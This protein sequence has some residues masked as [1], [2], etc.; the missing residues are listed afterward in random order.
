LL[1]YNNHYLLRETSNMVNK[2]ISDDLFI[3]GNPSSNKS[4][5][6]RPLDKIITL[7]G[8]VE[9]IDA[10]NGLGNNQARLLV[11]GSQVIPHVGELYTVIFNESN[12]F[13]SNEDLTYNPISQIFTV[14]SI[15][16]NY[17]QP[18]TLDPLVLW[19]NATFQDT[20]IVPDLTTGD[21]YIGNSQTSGSIFL[22]AISSTVS[23]QGK[24]IT[25]IIETNNIH[26]KTADP[27]ILWPTS[28]TQNISIGPDLTS[29][30]ISIGGSLI[31]GRINLG[32]NRG[33]LA[34]NKVVMRGDLQYPVITV[35]T[36]LTSTTTTVD[37]DHSSIFK[38][39]TEPLT[40][41]PGSTTTFTILCSDCLPTS[42]IFVSYNYTG[43]GMIIVNINPEMAQFDVIIGNAIGGSLD[44]SATLSFWVINAILP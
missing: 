26:S 20:R 1:N 14:P 12:G 5:I 24:I 7:E 27:L 4:T 28:T 42:N 40:G 23:V 22:G 35:Y 2:V 38:V 13:G 16:T 43:S 10:Y 15:A 30:N 31:T 34:S 29:G 44:A 36:Q 39:V 8:T 11:N 21:I 37:A 3:S 17:I 18:N 25:P 6:K 9:I 19:P 33:P 32:L 41:G